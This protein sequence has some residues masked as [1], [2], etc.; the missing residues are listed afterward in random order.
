MGTRGAP[1]KAVDD[2]AGPVGLQLREPQAVLQCG[3]GEE[4]GVVVR[5]RGQTVSP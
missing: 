4:V 3:A 5:D 1:V 2:P